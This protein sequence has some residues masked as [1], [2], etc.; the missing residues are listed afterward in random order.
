MQTPIHNYD[1]GSKSVSLLDDIRIF[2]KK[3]PLIGDLPNS[4]LSLPDE[5]LIYLIAAI[6][7]TP[8]SSP[9]FSLNDWHSFLAQLDPQGIFP[10]IAFHM[11]N[12]PEECCPPQEIRNYLNQIFLTAAARNLCNGRQIQKVTDALRD[13]GIPVILLKGHA[14]AR[15]LYPD[16]ALRQSSDIDL[17][18]Q[19]HNIR[20]SE[21]I[22]EKMG[23]FCHVKTFYLSQYVYHHEVFY[24]P[25]KGLPIELH[26]KIDNSFK[27][28]PEEWLESAFSRRIPIRSG[29]LLCDTFSHPDHLLYL[30]FHNVYQ[31]WS[32]RL[33]W[34]YD[35]SLLTMQLK[36][37]DEWKE[38]IKR[39]VEYHIRISLEL[40]LTVASLWTGCELNE[41]VGKFSTWPVPHE[42]ELQLVK[43]AAMRHT[44]VYSFLYLIM[45]DKLGIREKFRQVWQ[46]ILPPSSLLTTFRRSPSPIDIPLAHFRRWFLILKYL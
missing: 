37:P 30:A 9:N 10:L 16:P 31:H 38:L 17:L 13:A 12:W 18:V 34:V 11:H 23:Y 40:S 19:P 3:L 45:K 5:F 1:N 28:F 27:L 8:H 32:M 33:D 22:L 29:D 6:R 4:I 15:I 24:P 21:E 46:F 2:H 42:R 20:A 39:S 44:F 7:N 43:Y 25:G 41:K 14:L 26:W 36:K 35:T